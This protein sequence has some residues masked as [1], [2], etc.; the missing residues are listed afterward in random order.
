[1][2]V[3]S[4]SVF[5]QL[6]NTT[7]EERAAYC[8][9]FPNIKSC[10]TIKLLNDKPSFEWLSES[11]MKSLRVAEDEL[12]KKILDSKTQKVEYPDK[13]TAQQLKDL[14]KLMRSKGLVKDNNLKNPKENAL[15]EKRLAEENAAKKKRLA[16][17]NAAKKKKLDAGNAAKKLAEENAANEKFIAKMK[18]NDE[19]SASQMGYEEASD[20][21]KDEIE[22][23]LDKDKLT[24]NKICSELMKQGKDEIIDN[25]S[26]NSNPDVKEFPDALTSPGEC[27]TEKTFKTK[28]M[29]LFTEFDDEKSSFFKQM[30]QKGKNRLC[31]GLSLHMGKEG[32][33]CK[34]Y[35]ELAKTQC[36]ENEKDCRDK[37]WGDFNTCMGFKKDVDDNN[38]INA[39]NSLKNEV[40]RQYG[41]CISFRKLSEEIQAPEG[42][43]WDGPEEVHSLVGG[44]SCLRAKPWTADFFACKRLVNTFNGFVVGDQARVVANTGWT[45]NEN[46]QIQKTAT[47][48]M[49]Q[50]NQLNAGLDAQRKTFNHKKDQE[51]ANTAF[52]GAQAVTLGTHLTSYP[53]P[54]QLSRRCSLD[55]PGSGEDYSIHPAHYCAIEK[56]WEEVKGIKKEVFANEDTKRGMR[57]ELITAGSKAVLAGFKSNQFA[58]MA[59]DVKTLKEAFNNLEDNSTT[60]DSQIELDYCKYNPTATHCS[61]AGTRVTRDGGFQYGS[62]TSQNAG[63]GTYDIGT[64]DEAF[65]EY[66]ED[67]LSEAQRKAIEDLGGIIDNT[68]ADSFDNGFNKVGAGS[69]NKTS[70][71]GGGTASAPGG[72]AGGGAAPGKGKAG[73]QDKFSVSKS[74]GLG[75]FSSGAGGKTGFSSGGSGRKKNSSK[76]PF[77]NM[78]GSKKG[79]SVASQGNNDIAPANSA[80]FDKISKR[81]GKISAE[82]RLINLQGLTK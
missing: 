26:L 81:Y 72:G 58:K 2:L 65:G 27:I 34:S 52:F 44:H 37:H 41:T 62:I 11:H 75:S 6:L 48:E 74:G 67:E 68:S 24:I 4:S 77:S 60:N 50:G 16:E 53:T 61:S 76:N 32:L 25:G 12:N 82:N 9:K 17:E 73:G 43:K 3:V 66:N 10:V 56:S 49:A 78:F 39:F 23:M 15:K 7:K 30:N 31:R 42:R 40:H 46:R 18:K 35:L 63:G 20:L 28:G 29:S 51:L 8:K 45:M 55:D 64:N 1:M 69:F 22:E 14:D 38:W 79:R 70:Q 71:G 80:L 13:L 57:M 59:T 5:G 47:A 19:I 54:N 21:L 33:R 36:K